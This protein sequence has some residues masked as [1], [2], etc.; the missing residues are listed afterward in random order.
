MHSRWSSLYVSDS[1][2]V[3]LRQRTVLLGVCSGVCILAGNL[4]RNTKFKTSANWRSTLLASFLLLSGLLNRSVLGLAHERV[5]IASLQ[6]NF[7]TN[8]H[9]SRG[10]ERLKIPHVRL[11]STRS[12]SSVCS[13]LIS[14]VP[15]LC[16]QLHGRVRVVGYLGPIPRLPGAPRA[17]AAGTEMFSLF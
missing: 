10:A 14:Q 17:D 9:Y 15:C 5:L 16:C 13:S 8:L 11:K 4:T 6:P 1:V 12:G 3:P 7:E 2:R